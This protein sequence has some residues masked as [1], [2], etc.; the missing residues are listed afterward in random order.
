MLV[1]WSRYK[2]E[3]FQMVTESRWEHVP[4]V[5]GCA[6]GAC[7]LAETF[8]ISLSQNV[9]SGEVLFR[10]NRFHGC[11]RKFEWGSNR[12]AAEPVYAQRPGRK[13]GKEL[14]NRGNRPMWYG[15]PGNR[16]LLQKQSWIV[17]AGW[18]IGCSTRI[19]DV[20]SQMKSHIETLYWLNP[21][22]MIAHH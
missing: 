19:W 1:L 7:S 2:P 18:R 14:Q 21:V 8:P 11:S 12:D 6:Y 22:V 4:Y 16:L 3:I 17:L 9:V 5:N 15:L 13:I 20:N 10:E